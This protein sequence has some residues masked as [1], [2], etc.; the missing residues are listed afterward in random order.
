MTGIYEFNMRLRKPS[1]LKGRISKLGDSCSSAV[2]Y[3][4]SWSNLWG[5]LK[6]SK[7]KTGREALFVLLK[8]VKENL[9]NP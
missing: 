8:H 7:E 6:G 1:I 2:D 9:A 3:K 4:K 5:T